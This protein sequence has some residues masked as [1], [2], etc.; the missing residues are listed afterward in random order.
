MN[1]IAWNTLARVHPRRL[2]AVSTCLL[3]LALYL[4]TTHVEPQGSGGLS[5]PME[6]R[7]FRSETHLVPFYPRYLAERWI[8]NG[9]LTS[10]SFRFNCDFAD[11]LYVHDWLYGDGKYSLVWYDNWPL[12]L[13]FAAVSFCFAV[14]LWK[15]SSCQLRFATVLGILCG[16]AGVAV[17]LSHQSLKSAEWNGMTIKQRHG[18]DP[19]LKL[20]TVDPNGATGVAHKS[21][22]HRSGSISVGGAESGDY[23][24]NYEVVAITTN[25]FKMFFNLK[26]PGKP[27]ER[28]LIDFPF[29]T[30]TYTNWNN[31]QIQGKFL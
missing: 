5:G 7:V 1:T 13:S 21:A 24:F 4:V 18:G 31:W 17:Y 19:V 30:V 11:H 14:V 9:S 25:S 6:V 12:A 3:Y 2:F 27:V 28:T 10:A 8:R 26:R 23:S 22:L 15:K 20:R 29:N 16:F